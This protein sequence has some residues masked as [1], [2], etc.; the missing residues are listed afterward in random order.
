MVTQVVDPFT[1]GL[2]ER[3]TTILPLLISDP[4]PTDR[5]GSGFDQDWALAELLSYSWACYLLINYDGTFPIS[6]S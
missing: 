6:T 2:R 5:S 1:I 3:E 4:V